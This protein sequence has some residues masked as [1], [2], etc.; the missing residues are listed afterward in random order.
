[1]LG[2]VLGFNGK[3]LAKVALRGLPRDPP[4]ADFTGF[5]VC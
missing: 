5:A 3:Q 1:M 4:K 2:A